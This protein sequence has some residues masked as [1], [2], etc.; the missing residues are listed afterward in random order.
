MGIIAVIT[1]HCIHI[2]HFI[3]EMHAKESR[4]SSDDSL[5]VI[6]SFELLK[7]VQNT[8]SRETISFINVL[9]YFFSR[10]LTV[11]GPYCCF[12]NWPHKVVFMAF[13]FYLS[14][15]VFFILFCVLFIF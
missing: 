15:N 3:H 6:L 9:K 14:E 1:P 4:C 7:S 5:H 2:L 10:G 12:I 13:L 8:S 11:V